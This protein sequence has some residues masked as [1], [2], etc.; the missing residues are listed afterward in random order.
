MTRR[1]RT[2]SA[3]SRPLRRSSTAMQA[4]AFPAVPGDEDDFYNSF[5]NCRYCDFTRICSRRRVYES[6]AKAADPDI[7]AWFDVAEAARG[8]RSRDDGA[9]NATSSDDDAARAQI[10]EQLGRDAVRRGRRRHRQDARPGRPL[11]RLGAGRQARSRSWSRSRSRRRPRRSCATG[12]AAS[13]R[14]AS[15][16][17]AATWH[18][19]QR[20]ARCPG[21][22]A[23]LDH[24]RLLRR[25]A[26]L[27]RG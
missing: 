21:P 17:G 10:R 19:L 22:R 16:T 8:R 23:D 18:A 1:R 7:L 3:S 13:W 2:G 4:G 27:V 15:P 12:S 6:Q 9:S 26:A 25:R 11:R 20:S 24:P 14:R 5:D